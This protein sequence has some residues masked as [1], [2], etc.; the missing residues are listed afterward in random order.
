MK[1]ATGGFYYLESDERGVPYLCALAKQYVTEATPVKT[2]SPEDDTLIREV[3]PYLFNE[4]LVDVV[5]NAG[6]AK[7]KCSTERYNEGWKHIGQVQ[8]QIPVVLAVE[9][10]VVH[11]CPLKDGSR[12][13][14]CHRFAFELPYTSRLTRDDSLVTCQE[15]YEIGKPTW[16][17]IQNILRIQEKD[18]EGIKCC[19]SCADRADGFN[20]ALEEVKEI[21]EGEK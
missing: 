5:W 20:Q 17:A 18:S 6:R 11:A 13:G 3:T 8:D 4:F 7:E 19:Q 15:L 1:S 9:T 10:S 16:I 21:I 12:T 14:C 2:Y